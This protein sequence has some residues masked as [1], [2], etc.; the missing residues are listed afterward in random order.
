MD[1]NGRV[2][3]EFG[4][5]VV[6]NN[7]VS[8]S[9][10][11][12]GRGRDTQAGAG[13]STQVGTGAA[14]QAGAGAPTR[15]APSLSLPK[16]GGALRGMGEKFAANPVTG[17]AS[18][19]VPLA[20]TEGRGGFGPSLQLAYDSG[21]GNG[22]FGLGWSLDVPSIS[23]RTDKGVPRY[24]D[25]GFGAY[26]PAG[27][28]GPGGPYDSEGADVFQLSGAEDLVPAVFPAA[29]TEGTY[30]ITAYR[31][32]T[33]GLW[34]RIE[35]WRDRVS[36]DTHWRVTSKENVTSV[37]GRSPAA[38]ITDPAD[39]SGRRRVFRWLLEEVADDLGNITAYTYKQEDRSGV[40]DTLPQERN[41]A[42]TGSANRYLKRVRYGNARPGVADDF[43]F[44]VVLDYGEHDPESPAPDEIRPW[45][46][47]QDVFSNRRAGF[48][49]RTYRLCRRILM[50]HHFPELGPD[51][52]PVRA[53]V[54]DHQPDPVATKLTALRERGYVRDGSGYR[55]LDNPALTF[56]YSARVVS[57]APGPLTAELGDSVP[58]LTGGHRWT[59][60]DGEGIPGLLAEQGGTWYYRPNLG[61]G[62]LGAPR[63]VDPLPS[64]ASLSRGWQ[65]MDLAGEGRP[66]LTALATATP[67]FHR[68]QD[69]LGWGAFT[70]FDALPDLPWNDPALRFVDLTGDGLSD[71]LL[72]TSEGFRWHPSRGPDGF[73][74][75]TVVAAELT[76][77]R[78]PLLVFADA[79][80]SVYLAD[81][82]GD[83]LTDLVRIG[84][85][86][87][88]YWPSLGHGVFGPKVSM[89]GAPAFDH[90]DRF[91]QRRVHLSDVDGS[92]PADLLYVGPDGC[93]VWF[94]ESGNA[95]SSPEPIDAFLPSDQTSGSVSVA[96]VLGRGTACL[97]VAEPRP[98][99]EPQLRYLDLMAAGKPHLMTAMD[100]G[101]GLRTSTRYASSTAFYLADKAAGQPWFTT[102]P[103]PVMV[104]AET[105]AEDTV[106]GTTLATTHRYRHGHYDG[107][108]REFR[109]FGY[110]EDRDDLS[111]VG[112][113]DPLR[114]PTA[115]VRRWQHTGWYG[116]LGRVSRQFET[117]YWGAGTDAG[118][119]PLLPDTVLPAGLSA[120]EEREAVR[121][122]RGH[123]LREEIHTEPMA[124]G[125]W[126]SPYSVTE[127]S[128]TLHVTQPRGWGSYAVLFATPAETL[129]VHTEGD[130]ADPRIEHQLQLDVDDWGNVL[131]SAHVSYPRRAATDPEQLRLHITSGEQDVVN[132]IGET[133][134]W[135]VGLPVE[136]RDYEIG[137]APQ[138]ADTAQGV[139]TETEVRAALTRAAAAPEVPYQDALSG[140]PQRRLIARNLQT[141]Y[142]DD[143]S[144]E[145]PLGSVGLRALPWRGLQQAYAPGHIAALFGDRV[146]DAALAAAGYVA[147]DGG[148]WVPS[149]RQV[150]DPEHFYLPVE[151]VDPFGSVWTTG[152]DV[153]WLRPVRV[154]DPGG[155]TVEVELNYRLLAAWL[156]TDANGLRSGVRFDEV[157]RVVATAVIGKNGDGD[158]LDLDSAEVSDSDDPTSSV[159]Y[160]FDRIPVSFRTSSRERHGAANPRWQESWTYVDGTGRAVLTKAQAEPAG[161]QAAS[162]WVGTGRTVHNNKGNP[163][164][165]YEPYFAPD[166]TFDT[167]AELVLRGVT[168]VLYYDPLNRLIR[169]DNPD[170]T[171]ATVR[172]DAWEEQEWDGNDTVLESDWYA[173][174]IALP[175]DDPRYTAANATAPHAATPSRTRF[176]TL[177]RP[178]A[179]VRD[180]G[181]GV[182]FETVTGRDVQGHELTTTDP[183]GLLVLERRY[184][185]LGHQAYSRGSDSGERWQ[186]L[187]VAEKL[188]LGWD[189]RGTATRWRY[190]AL[191]RP[192]HAYATPAG[193]AERLRVLHFYG[194]SQSDGQA[195]NLRN[196]PC[197][198]FD[199]AGLLRTLDV[200]LQGNT[201]S[202]ERQLATDAGT[203]PDWSPLA[204]IADLASAL[205][206]AAPRLEA[207]P[208]RTTA[209][210]D[211]LNRP[212]QVTAPDGSV[213]RNTYNEAN[214][215]ER[216]EVREA[217]AADWTPMVTDL[218]YNARGQRTLIALGCGARTAYTYE[219]D[220]FRLSVV[221][222]RGAGGERL[223]LLHYTY[224]PVGNVVV[225]DDA[226]QDT[227]FFANAVVPASRVYG[228]EPTYRLATAAGR[229]HIG[230]NSPGQ[231]GPDGPTLYQVP[232]VNDATAMRRYTETYHYDAAGNIERV[233]HSAGSDGSWTRRYSTAADGNRLL[234]TS[235]PGDAD[236]VFSAAY[237]YDPVGNMTSMP[238]LSRLDWDADDRLVTAAL[239]GG[240]TASYQYDSQG[241]RVRATVTSGG[242]VE[243]RVYVGQFEHYRKTV[244]GRTVTDRDTSHVIDGTH[245]VAV[246]DTTTIDDGATVAEPLP[247]ARYQLA[248]QLGSTTVELDDTSGVMSY[249]EYHPYGTTSFRSA[250]GAAQVSL[251]R[252]RFSGKEND[253]ETGF[254]YHGARYYA[255]WLGRWT[256]TD[257][258]QPS[259]SGNP[260][261]YGAFNP[262][263]FTDPDGRS[264]KD[265]VSKMADAYRGKAVQIKEFTKQAAQV[266][267]IKPYNQQGRAG[268]S[269]VWRNWRKGV[270]LTEAEHPLAGAAVKVFNKAWKYKEATTIVIERDIATMKTVIDKRLIKAVKSGAM[271]MAEFADKS[272]R[273]FLK[274]Y[275][276][277]RAQ[278]PFGA[279]AAP[280]EKVVEA[281]DKA[282]QEALPQ[283]AKKGEQAGASTTKML[284]ALKKEAT[285]VKS[286]LGEAS[287]AVM[288][289]LKSVTAASHEAAPVLKAVAKESKF[290]GKLVPG[291]G[292]A[293]SVAAVA[294]DLK[295]KDYLQAGIDSIAAVPG[296]GN[297]VA[298]IDMGVQ[299]VVDHIA[300][301]LIHTN[302]PFRAFMTRLFN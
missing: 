286:F 16:A 185:M 191:R 240:G 122:L 56:T 295:N 107:V 188:V 278:N 85:G 177:G 255:A 34:S 197:A 302:K 67:G 118:V 44:E 4:E 253:A 216:V 187:D 282:T 263:R 297:V 266:G 285:G 163:I 113:T 30:D 75:S 7:V 88:A 207:T 117:E 152:Y 27:A 228:Y 130:P 279:S 225:A 124:D 172:F 224:D 110:V 190:D 43:A 57:A 129:T 195:H 238:H 50:F 87:I 291:I 77:E 103:F 92:G 165:Q 126:G 24:L 241:A 243:T 164:K 48:D 86:E 14:T 166:E 174:R 250:K 281:I 206:A 63:P 102:L 154:A 299:A 132:D 73:G 100:N 114:Q 209:S 147:R 25:D 181:A 248:D 149:G 21:A 137:G 259:S 155:N 161:N 204:E 143:L 258:V 18:V 20:L 217:G 156:M 173:Q 169:T 61:G 9:G 41:R 290:A 135:R 268:W 142:S 105:R 229:E 178:H 97:V 33:E 208:Y 257:P 194:E 223:Q 270:R 64:G 91:D 23:R 136:H 196:R 160:H 284:T 145:L 176:D 157:G 198:V 2:D 5:A 54:L 119:G 236:G 71:V 3:G 264:E 99:G 76:E 261:A 262:L 150:P 287:H 106:A 201:V 65:L 189:G 298:G 128:Y 47:R 35:R 239:G 280:R 131:R 148:W 10:V 138:P 211:A 93:R 39:T 12:G 144:A 245:R 68:R 55:Q 13:A 230:Q 111:A 247:V 260:Y 219:P 72:T 45:P 292:T 289:Q 232:H 234:A 115:V 15:D 203:E 244:A 37:Y 42:G 1:G 11:D 19:S 29:R 96:D 134:R 231:P 121:A 271:G 109:G 104:V 213:T 254:Y 272:K 288:P 112:P 125:S 179:T 28:E 70:P 127:H 192:T 31:P 301:P 212:V 80:Q 218:D 249:E 101:M 26:G 22:P 222:A 220:T 214:L 171:F 233:V 300:I 36:G 293:L 66:A 94:N 202:E 95:W 175:T 108:E 277:K 283:L 62:L 52:V 273:A 17:T 183:R 200:D 242:T 237:T 82:T 146:D 252:Y 276:S 81:M 235:V 46:V 246:L 89:A 8:G 59:D 162:R 90:P 170:G 53:T 141:Y 133:G 275:D 158:V 58:Q 186:L 151:T 184:D 199:G 167:E 205:T 294:S 139:F 98:D 40:D 69:D 51:P 265:I 221:D 49:I 159:T 269:T 38:R 79:A 210:Y 120:A 182:L 60:L 84:N 32:R 6:E 251:K 267:D 274:A 78:G 256:S 226:A 180:N 153:H 116:E 296:I 74:D 215:L 168:S 123:T 140:G 83:G 227:L 193:A